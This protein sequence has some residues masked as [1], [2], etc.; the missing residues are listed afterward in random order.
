MSS[1]LSAE[2]VTQLLRPIHPSRVS[3]RDG[4]SHLEAYDVRAHLNRIF[5]FGRW[6][7]DL[8]PGE[9][10]QL[11]EQVAERS[12]DGRTWEVVSVGYRATMCLKV[13]APDGTFLASYTEAAAGDATNFPINKRA[14][15][16]DFAMKTAESQAL[17][18]CV[19]NLGDQFGLS[20][21]QKGSRDAL[22]KRTLVMAEDHPTEN[23]D[24]A[25]DVAPVI[26]EHGEEVQPVTTTDDSGHA[27]SPTA[28]TPP[29]DAPAPPPASSPDRGEALAAE[30]QRLRDKAIEV[31][32]TEDRTHALQLL[33]KVNFDAGK[34]KVLN[35]MV[36][37]ENGEEL[38]LRVLIDSLIKQRSRSAA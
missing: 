8:L 27:T 36:R 34:G 30:A 23:G 24:V 20:L 26:P 7:A 5:G 10:V 29:V 13:Y 28:T 38:T 17:K 31:S 14:D 3:V 9:P 6:S 32:K 33:T 16:H 35:Q 4:L 19:T 2:Q 1:Y 15:A 12:K 37:A 11:Y 25:A 22:V 18:R 21:Y